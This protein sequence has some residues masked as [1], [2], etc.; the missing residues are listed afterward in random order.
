[1]GRCDPDP[2]RMFR[3][4]RWVYA[5][6]LA[7]ARARTLGSHLVILVDEGFVHHSGSI[8][9]SDGMER[10]REMFSLMPRASLYLELTCESGTLINRLQSRERTTIRHAESSEAELRQDIER[11]IKLYDH[12]SRVIRQDGLPMLQIRTD[13]TSSSAIGGIILDAIDGARSGRICGRFQ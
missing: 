11:Q 1:M 7:Y 4:Y 12:A 3:V 2:Y 13:T 9:S 5:T 8:T 6:L 10:L